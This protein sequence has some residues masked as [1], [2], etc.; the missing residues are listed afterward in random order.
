MKSKYFDIPEIGCLYLDKIIVEGAYY[1]Q[2]FTCFSD[3]GNLF[4][5]VCF[6]K[7]A[8]GVGYLLARTTPENIIDLLTNRITLRDSFLI[9]IKDKYLIFQKDEKTL[10][11]SESKQTLISSREKYLPDEGEFL[12]SDKNEFTD[13]INYYKKISLKKKEMNLKELIDSLNF[14]KDKNVDFLN[15]PVLITLSSNSVG[16]RAACTIRNVSVG[17]DWEHGQIRIEPNGKL[18]KKE[19]SR[20]IKK[21]VKSMEFSGQ[22]F[23]AC[24]ICIL[25]VSKQDSYC[26][27]CGQRLK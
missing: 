18:I 17:F 24:P 19:F 27:H 25:K 13:E 2:L 14:I 6:Q 21:E 15:S 10:I 7:N 11:T 22:K 5:C 9:D 8:E 16:A 3:S 20:D 4:L 12:D 26:R 1:P 23:T